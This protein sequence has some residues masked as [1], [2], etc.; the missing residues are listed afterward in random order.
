MDCPLPNRCRSTEPLCQHCCFKPT[1]TERRQV[2]AFVRHYVPVRPLYVP[3]FFDIDAEL[4]EVG[5][6]LAAERAP[7][8]PEVYLAL[9]SPAFSLRISICSR[10]IGPA[11]ALQ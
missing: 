2:A 3:P 1:G 7:D 5:I 6:R 8:G 10:V 9:P 4:V 11:R